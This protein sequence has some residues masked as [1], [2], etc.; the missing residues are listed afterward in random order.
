MEE[1]AVYA[2]TRSNPYGISY[3]NVCREVMGKKQKEQLGRLIGFRFE[4]HP[5]INLPEERLV[6]IEK[7]LQ[8]RVQDLLHL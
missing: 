3:E 5:S 1:L 6:T 8:K 4:R 7:H 2:A